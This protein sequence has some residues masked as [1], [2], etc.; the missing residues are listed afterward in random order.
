MPKSNMYQSLHTTVFGPDGEPVEIQIRTREM[1]AV[2]EYGI[3]AHWKYK[4]GVPRGEKGIQGGFDW[5][6]E[7]MEAGKDAG[8][9]QDLV[10]SLKKDMFSDEVFV[11]TPKGEVKE[12]PQGATCLDFAYAVHSD[13]G[14][15]CQ[16]AKIN[17]RIM[18]LKTVLKNGDIVEIITAKMHEP[19]QQWLHWIK[20]SKAENH[21]RRWL[22]QRESKDNQ[23]RGRRKLE[24]EM[25]K[26]HLDTQDLFKQDKEWEKLARQY[27]LPAAAELFEAVGYG[28]I[29]AKQ[30]LQK[31]VPSLRDEA[32]VPVG[33]QKP[34]RGGVVVAGVRD[35]QIRFA[36][37]CNPLP[38]EPIVGYLSAG[39]GCSI[40]RQGCFNITDA[41]RQQE[42]VLK[43]EW[44]GAAGPAGGKKDLYETGIEVKALDR[45]NLLSDILQAIGSTR[46]TINAASASS[47]PGGRARARFKVAIE[48]VSDLQKVL[49]AVARVKDVLQ[50]ERLK[51]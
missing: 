3:A 49:N 41:S 32:A 28:T 17:G 25:K 18:P 43:A 23:E 40:H 21:I 34:E 33:S 11:F 8:S 36:Q 16:G 14:N 44:R 48:D 20:T 46:V 13:V 24:E 15:R 39:R 26:Y 2:A 42:R 6:R 5:L 22:K 38:G 27:A 35:M 1:H 19:K 29:S 47:L 50:V 30:V 10:E 45:V 12:M 9:T 4:E 31:M 7:A 37:C 51:G